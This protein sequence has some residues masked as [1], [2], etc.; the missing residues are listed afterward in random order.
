MP[1]ILF[2]PDVTGQRTKLFSVSSDEIQLAMFTV[3][4]SCLDLRLFHPVILGMLFPTKVPP[5]LCT[6]TRWIRTVEA[7]LEA[8]RH[9][10]LVK[11]AGYF[12]DLFGDLHL[13]EGL[14][15]AYRH[16]LTSVVTLDDSAKPLMIKA[17]QCAFWATCNLQVTDIN[18]TQFAHSTHTAG[19]KLQSQV[20]DSESTVA[21]LGLCVPW[22]RVVHVVP[23]AVRRGVPPRPAEHKGGV[24]ALAEQCAAT[25]LDAQDCRPS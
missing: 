4:V 18:R 9:P 12:A 1:P 21:E 10:S 13:L 7:M 20:F 15:S 6:G 16:H 3:P 25:P 8:S 11:S 2:R 19:N 24:P 23:R 5:L 22:T 17:V 14:A